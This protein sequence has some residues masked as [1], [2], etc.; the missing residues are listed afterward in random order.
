MKNE[1]IELIQDF[2]NKLTDY[3]LEAVE[4]LA[5]PIEM[6][7]KGKDV[8][9]RQKLQAIDIF[10]NNLTEEEFAIWL[11]RGEGLRF[12][13]IAQEMNDK[14]SVVMAKYKNTLKKLKNEHTDNTVNDTSDSG[15]SSRS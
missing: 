1:Y 4:Y 12:I 14:K 3:T 6:R 11:L 5:Q 9:I 13:D 2:K 10:N 15:M 8:E 7:E